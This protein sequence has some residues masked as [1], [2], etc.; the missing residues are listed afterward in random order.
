MLKKP[1]D[2]IVRLQQQLRPCAQEGR[3]PPRTGGGRTRAG[4][5]TATVARILELLV[6]RTLC[7]PA[8]HTRSCHTQSASAPAIVARSRTEGN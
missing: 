1:L 4:H 5:R 2:L 7:S 6:L 8:L 3:A